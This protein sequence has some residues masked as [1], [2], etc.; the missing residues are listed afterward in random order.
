MELGHYLRHMGMP[1]WK[2]N[3]GGMVLVV[4][5]MRTFDLYLCL[6]SAHTSRMSQIPLFALYKIYTVFLGPYLGSRAAPEAT[7]DEQGQQGMS[8]RQQKMKKR[9]EKGDPRVKRL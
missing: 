2:R 8:K 6:L 7:E 1:N 3:I 9:S 5:S 4:I